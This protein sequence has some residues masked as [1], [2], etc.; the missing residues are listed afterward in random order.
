[1][2]KYSVIVSDLG[3]VLIP[4]DY[5]NAINRI[6]EVEKKIQ[7]LDP[8]YKAEY[9]KDIKLKKIKERINVLSSEGNRIDKNPQKRNKYKT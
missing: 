5:N 1:M 6:V 2:R 4:F 8:T 7:H 9:T 3:N